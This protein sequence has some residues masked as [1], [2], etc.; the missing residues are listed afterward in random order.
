MSAHRTIAKWRLGWRN[1]RYGRG[2]QRDSLTAKPPRCR[3]PNGPTKST[4][5]S[6]Y[7]RRRDR[8]R[9]PWSMRPRVQANMNQI[10]ALLSRMPLTSRSAFRAIRQR[11]APGR[12][13]TPTAPLRAAA[14]RCTAVLD[15]CDQASL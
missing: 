13:E 7:A 11:A 10:H 12:S 5:V 14:E 6:D 4:T 3:A 1:R 9:W 8:L 2:A 15:V